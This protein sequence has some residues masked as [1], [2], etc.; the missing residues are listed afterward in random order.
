L[1]ASARILDAWD[2]P[3]AELN[4]LL[5]EHGDDDPTWRNV[6]LDPADLAKYKVY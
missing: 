6:L 4:R 1:A 5:P 2:V 3:V